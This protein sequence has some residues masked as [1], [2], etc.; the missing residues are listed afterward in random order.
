MVDNSS[1][2]MRL[3]GDFH[4][5]PSKEYL[6]LEVLVMYMG[7]TADHMRGLSLDPYP[8]IN[9]FSFAGR[10]AKLYKPKPGAYKQHFTVLDPPKGRRFSSIK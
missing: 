7:M 8:C 2:W 6:V 5:G 9:P 1:K 10:R 3:C 4:A